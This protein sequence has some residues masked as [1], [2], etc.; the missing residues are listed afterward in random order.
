[1]YN[2]GM[3]IKLK[4][5]SCEMNPSGERAA[6]WAQNASALASKFTKLCPRQEV[7]PSFCWFF[8]RLPRFPHHGFPLGLRG[9]P[10][11]EGG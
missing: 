6:H 5:I 8:A 1:M 11:G 3:T 2:L 4:A 9:A 7:S 10:L